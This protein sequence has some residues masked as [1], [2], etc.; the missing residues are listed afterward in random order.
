MAARVLSR[1]SW[2]SGDNIPVSKKLIRFLDFD[3]RIFVANKLSDS[4]F[5]FMFYSLVVIIII[6]IE[7]MSGPNVIV[8]LYFW[9]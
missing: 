1:S 2:G 9:T 3:S 5:S 7:S 8:D 6:I 4:V